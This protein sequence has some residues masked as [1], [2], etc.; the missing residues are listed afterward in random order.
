M[1]LFLLFLSGLTTSTPRSWQAEATRLLGQANLAQFQNQPEEAIQAL[2]QLLELQPWRT[3]LYEGIGKLQIE[4]GNRDAAISAYQEAYH[5]KA[6]DSEGVLRLAQLQSETGN[7]S[8]ARDL[9]GELLTSKELDDAT[10]SQV[11]VLLKKIADPEEIL[12]RM[13]A[14]LEKDPTNARALYIKGV[15]L[16][17][18]NSAQAV[19]AL[20][21]AGRKDERVQA[22]AARLLESLDA[23]AQKET[24]GLAELEIGQGLVE[25]GEWQAAEMAFQKAVDAQPDM[26]DAWAF[27]AEA[28]QNQGKS[29]EMEIEHALALAP[30]SNTVQALAAFYYRRLGKPEIALIY[31]H[32]AAAQ[33][34]DSTYWQVELGKTLCELND[35]QDALPYFDRAT[36]L[37]PKNAQNWVELARFSLNYGIEPARLGLPAARQAVLLA[38]KD[39]QA[40]DILGALFLTQNDL[41]SAERFLQQSLQ[42]DADNSEAQLHLGQVYLASGNLEAARPYLDEALRSS[43]ET[44]VG[45]LAER[46]IRQYYPLQ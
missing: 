3:D 17:P 11:V 36:E 35:Y 32:A 22:S 8:Q 14:W 12:A 33:E 28:K 29:A 19:I 31:L 1:I 43:P 16:A 10:F 44:A 34:P 9:V 39:P 15:Y 20:E 4:T 41:A 46:L 24:T 25:M 40:L 45:R 2:R 38:P 5:A 27:L 18:I 13:D 7:S 21:Q 37:E 30:G 26:A 6:L 23:A 42:Q